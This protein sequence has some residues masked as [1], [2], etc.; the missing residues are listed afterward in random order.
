MSTNTLSSRSH[1][2]ILYTW[3]GGIAGGFVG[4]V[5]MGI[6]LHW[7][8]NIM[9]FIGA[10]YGWPT[11]LG[12]WIAHLVNSLILGL[13]FAVIISQRGLHPESA[14]ITDFVT[15]GVVYAAAIGLVVVGV[16]LPITVNLLGVG[17][18]PEPNVPL[19]GALGALLVPFSVGVAHM[20]YGALLGVTYGWINN[21]SVSNLE[22]LGE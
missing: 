21:A 20:L 9:P 22:P 11:V 3:G 2:S 14:T 13:L 4:G 18:L 17:A 5:A 7:G 6:V 10:L 19:P 16:V 8:A 1:K 15:Y 12:G